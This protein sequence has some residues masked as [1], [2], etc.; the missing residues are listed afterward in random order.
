MA[1]SAPTASGKLAHCTALHCIRLGGRGETEHELEHV[2]EH[3]LE[4]LL[5]APLR[6]GDPGVAR[7]RLAWRISVRA[8]EAPHGL[9]G[10]AGAVPGS[11]RKGVGAVAVLEDADPG[12]A[13]RPC[14][15]CHVMLCCVV[16]CVGVLLRN[17]TESNRIDVMQD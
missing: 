14:M 17:R 1:G 11:L 16:L 13:K 5:D 10:A 15:S 12:R 2:L 9:V 6:P 4:D 7:R 8:R 3:V